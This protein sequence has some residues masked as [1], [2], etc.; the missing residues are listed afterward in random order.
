MARKIG[1]VAGRG[2]GG[3]KSRNEPKKE[4]QVQT[5]DKLVVSEG[6]QRVRGGREEKLA[7]PS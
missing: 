1:S 7:D 2:G 5:T 3:L 6:L 4:V